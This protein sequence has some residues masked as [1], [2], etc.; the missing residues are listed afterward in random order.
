M[1]NGLFSALV[2]LGDVIGPDPQLSAHEAHAR[3]EEWI[4]L[5]NAARFGP[6]LRAAW[7]LERTEVGAPIVDPAASPDTVAAALRCVSCGGSLHTLADAQLQCTG[8]GHV[9]PRTPGGWW[10]LGARQF[11]PL[12]HDPA[13]SWFAEP[14]WDDA[15]LERLLEAFAGAS[16]GGETLIL[17]AA[18]TALTGPDAAQR[19]T[20]AIR[21]RPLPPQTELIVVDEPLGPD[22]LATL[23]TCRTLPA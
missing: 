12:G 9:V 3:R 10:D 19:L 17:H 16:P 20:S 18:P 13:R 22:D 4:A 15:A 6:S 8:C 2:A 23:R 7:V 21:R 5:C 11:E 14:S 1:P